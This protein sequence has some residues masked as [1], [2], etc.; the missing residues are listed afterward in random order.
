[1]TLR[2]ACRACCI[3]TCATPGN[4]RPSSSA[5]DARSPT[6]NT[7]G[8]PG[9][10]RSFSTSTRP[11]RS[12]GTPSVLPKRRR[13]DAR[14][15]DDR[16]G[17]DP[18][19]AQPHRLVLDA[20]DGVFSRTST[21][22]FSSD[23]RAARPQPLGKRREDRRPRLDEHDARFRGVESTGTRPTASGARSR[24]CAPAISTP[25]GPPPTMTN[26]SMRRRTTGSASRS[27]TSYA[28]SIRPP[29]PQGI[30][31][32]L[33]RG[34]ELRPTRRWPKYELSAPAATIR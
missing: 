29:Q 23:F 9:I 2:A 14:G 28:S 33:Q 6:T 34:R 3:A 20:R 11:A 22:S 31:Q 30:V 4:G 10:V 17:L 27:A 1:M 32:R 26:V 18:L 24:R 8:W 21:P 19:V 25:V 15:P 12:S 13:G 7:S 5:S 16:A